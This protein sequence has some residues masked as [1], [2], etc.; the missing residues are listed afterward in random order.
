MCGS[1]R[2][3]FTYT[4]NVNNDNKFEKI[5]NGKVTMHLPILPNF[6]AKYNLYKVKKIMLIAQV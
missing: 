1:A 6:I 3:S 4:S 2:D 5:L